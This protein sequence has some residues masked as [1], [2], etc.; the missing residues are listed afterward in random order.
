MGS[1]T[2]G[3]ADLGTECYSVIAKYRAPQLLSDSGFSELCKCYSD[4]SRSESTGKIP[5]V[6]RGLDEESGGATRA[7]LTNHRRCS[8]AG[9]AQK[10]LANRTMTT[11]GQ[12]HVAP[13]AD[14][15]AVEVGCYDHE[16]I[17]AFPSF[18]LLRFTLLLSFKIRLIWE[19][20]L[21]ALRLQIWADLHMRLWTQRAPPTM[22]CVTELTSSPARHGHCWSNEPATVG[23][24]AGKRETEGRS[25]V[26]V[27]KTAPSRPCCCNIPTSKPVLAMPL[28]RSLHAEL[29]KDLGRAGVQAPCRGRVCR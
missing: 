27:R 22:V 1:V 20:L 14:F 28:R 25:P 6:S 2:R 17:A 15:A 21:W 26:P 19:A 23:H 10:R 13:C 12:G 4:P 7:S 18:F 11:L 16:R 9:A 3:L 8:G 24:G 29:C 5:A